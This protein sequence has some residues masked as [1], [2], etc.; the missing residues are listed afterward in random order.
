MWKGAG[1]GEG[2]SDDESSF[3]ILEKPNSSRR[4]LA[5]AIN[6]WLAFENFLAKKSLTN[7]RETDKESCF[8]LLYT[9][10]LPTPA[11]QAF[12][13]FSLFFG[14]RKNLSPANWLFSH[15]FS[16]FSL[17]LPWLFA[18]CFWFMTSQKKIKCEVRRM[19]KNCIEQGAFLFSVCT[20]L[21][22]LQTGEWWRR[23]EKY[24][25]PA[26]SVV[27]RFALVVVVVVSLFMKLFSTFLRCEVFS[28]NFLFLS[29]LRLQNWMMDFW[30]WT[31]F[32]SAFGTELFVRS[33]MWEWLNNKE[34]W[35]F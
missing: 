19:E 35:V 11:P 10:V 21:N 25:G 30:W 23:A 17:S 26:A 18:R 6:W 2:G 15:N 12:P 32:C 4:R 3:A 22:A 24:V 8:L 16:R 27:L 5:E 20:L 13:S 28:L 1:D 29:F 9:P 14:P 7:T 33:A 34:K 31:L